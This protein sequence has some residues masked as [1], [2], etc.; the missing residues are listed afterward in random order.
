MT[1]P[2]PDRGRGRVVAV[3]SGVGAILVIGG[4]LLGRV[5][6][7]VDYVGLAL[8]FLG[9]WALVHAILVG[10]GLTKLPA[11][12]TA[13]PT[14]TSPRR[15]QPASIRARRGEIIRIELISCICCAALGAIFETGG[16]TLREIAFALF[17]WAAG[18][19]L[20]L[21]LMGVTST[22]SKRR[23]QP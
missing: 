4:V 21:T 19:G 9:G 10:M 5:G 14:L 2:A 7:I 22:V 18:T 6:G 3:E 23:R 1:G 17:G 13:P 15:E 12:A 16:H 8:V 11:T 20:H